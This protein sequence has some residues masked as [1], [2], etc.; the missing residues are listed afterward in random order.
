MT[1]AEA[2]EYIAGLIYPNNEHKITPS[3]EL[4]ALYTII[5]LI[6]EG[7]G[8]SVS[9]EVLD[10]L[11]STSKT[12]ALS[13]NQGRA[14]KALVDGKANSTHT[15]SMSEVSGLAAKLNQIDTTIGDIN[16]ALETIIG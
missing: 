8:G 9:V 14:L 1:T 3:I 13:A 15:H 7:G 2:K 12:A 10:N 5:D 6:G 16:T 4:E 11:V